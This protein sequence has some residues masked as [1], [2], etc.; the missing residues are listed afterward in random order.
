MR[1][2]FSTYIE[3]EDSEFNDFSTVLGVDF[4]GGFIPSGC[5]TLFYMDYSGDISLI[6]AM[7][8]SDSDGN[9]IVVTNHICE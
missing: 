3:F 9:P 8:F 4:S 1:I 2:I 7:L 6:Q 5:G